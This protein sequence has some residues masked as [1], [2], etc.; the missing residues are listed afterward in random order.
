M[1]KSY[2]FRDFSYEI[3]YNIYM[4]NKE[5]ITKEAY[6]KLLNKLANLTDELDKTKSELSVT[7][8]ELNNAKNK[9]A[10]TS[11]GL[12]NAKD[13]LKSTSK[14]LVEA[15]LEIARLKEL[16][17]LR[18]MEMFARKAEQKEYL[19]LSLFDE[20]ELLGAQ[21]NL[22][23][24]EAK[25]I[26]VG[27]HKRVIKKASNFMNEIDESLFKKEIKHM[28]IE[29]D[30][31]RDINSD[32]IV[33]TLKYVPE[34]YVIQETHIHIYEAIKNGERTLVRADNTLKNHLG[35]TAICPELLSHVIYNKVVNSLP[36]YRQE[37]EFQL[38]NIPL[39][40]QYL[41]NVII[42]SFNL[43]KPVVDEIK[44]YIVNSEIT[45]SDET[46]LTVIKGIKDKSNNRQNYFIWAFSTGHGYAPATYYAVGDRSRN[47]LVS[48]LGTNKRY[49]TT[50]GYDS[51]LNVPNIT[52]IICMVHVR[53]KF[54][55]VVK[56]LGTK[57]NSNLAVTKYI[58]LISEMY[59]VDNAIA[60]K[61][62]DYNKIKEE[63]LKTLKPIMDTF[64]AY[65]KKDK[66]NV[67]SKSLFGKALSFAQNMEQYIYN[68]F[69]DGR[70]EL[71]NNA[72]ERKIKSIVIGRKNWMFSFTENGAK[73]TCGYYSLLKTAIEN[74]IN[75]EAYL[76]Y[77][78]NEF[79]SKNNLN[80]QDYLPWSNNIKKLFSIKPS[81][82]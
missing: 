44:T 38:K 49:L 82:D 60:K 45:R 24:D 48:N 23:K 68:I 59:Q 42:K 5:L 8:D 17:K 72:S 63:R 64:F 18:Q 12:D 70:L 53:R 16:L 51:Y 40:R 67:L 66:E 10:F 52:N 79:G 46:P 33:K 9:L 76:I 58:D 31:F 61:Y 62:T 78:F 43:I 39:T 80:P 56:S 26:I 57:N 6:D 77:L 3:C 28:T 75:P 65:V 47:T 32:E 37:K 30:G 35:K 1:I 73:V 27:E 21:Y 14:E 50:D 2:F 54:T 34:Q 11:S 22:E 41:S 36:L 74:N 19:Q 69:L 15:N 20:T 71:D 4:E 25:E 7:N 81:I 55:D 29:K 13:K